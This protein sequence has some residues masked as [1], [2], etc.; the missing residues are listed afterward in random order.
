MKILALDLST[1]TGWA[2]FKKDKPIEY[3]H[4]KIF[5]E[6]FDINNY[7]ERRESYPYNLID[8][9]DEIG[10]YCYELYL[11]F[12]PDI[13]IIENTVRGKNR[14]S[15]KLLEQ[16]HKAV[17]DHFKPFREK[18]RY[19]DV[20]KWRKILE[21]YLTKEDKAHNKKKKEPIVINELVNARGKITKKHLA[22][23][24]CAE[25]FNIQLKMKDNDIADALLIG[26]SYSVDKSR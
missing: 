21:V 9:S 3:G 5:V 22:V 16:I 14:H 11:Q 2:F 1:S 4:H 26:Y 12:K 7:P 19:R 13:I 20:S 23:R 10:S 18:V 17:L 15:Q 24:K 6:D 8:A 25:L